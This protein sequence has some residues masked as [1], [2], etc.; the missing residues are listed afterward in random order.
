[1]KT[2]FVIQH[3]P[4]EERKKLLLKIINVLPQ[5]VIYADTVNN[6]KETFIASLD[7]TIGHW[8]LED[9]VIL[10]PDFKKRIKNIHN[11]DDIF[12]SGFD[13]RKW[14][15]YCENIYMS[16]SQFIANLCVY[17]PG[18]YCKKLYEFAYNWEGW[19]KHKTGFDLCIRDFLIKNK[20]KYL[21]IRPSL[22][23]HAQVKSELGSRSKYRQ[24]SSFKKYYG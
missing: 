15:G 2:A 5:S 8:H 21:L 3:K 1:M 9:D 20:L 16:A 23:D 14:N 19:N 12:I 10:A 7:Q 22:V 6:P 11:C 13:R 4:T 17:I 18:K 24:S